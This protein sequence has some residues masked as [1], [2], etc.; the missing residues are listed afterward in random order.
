MQLCAA[1]MVTQGGTNTV[2]I[3]CGGSDHFNIATSGPTSRTITLASESI[4]V[5]YQAST[6]VWTVLTTDTPLAALDARFAPITGIPESAVT[7]LTADL[8][9]KAP[10]AAPTF[11]GHVTVPTPTS[12]TDAVT[13]TYADQLIASADAMVYKGVVDCSANPNY[14]AADAGWTYKISVAGKIGGASGVVVEV[15]DTIMC[16]VDG[17]AS[18]NQATVGTAWG[19][20]QV[21]ID[22]AVVGPTSATD[23]R[24]AIFNGATGK[25]IADGGKLVSDLLAKAGGTMSGAI[26]MGSNKITGATAGTTTGDVATYEQGMAALLTTQG[27]IPYASAANTPARLAKGTAFQI[28]RMNSGATAPEWAS[29]GAQLITE[30]VLG[31]DTASFDFTSI[32]ATYRHLLV[33]WSLRTDAAAAI[34][35]ASTNFNNDTTNAN[36][37]REFLQAAASSTTA[38]EKLA[39]TASRSGATITG[40]TAP[41][42]QFGHGQMLVHNYANVNFFKVASIEGSQWSARTTNGMLHYWNVMGWANTAAINRLTFTPVTGTNFKAQSVVALYG[43]G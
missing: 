39:T 16:A 6:A 43:I 15:G 7:N 17:T 12:G 14:P 3:S 4:L 21:N 42:S 2:T 19:V 20:T 36:Y 28:L 8:A 37:D 34:D 26:A 33:V 38:L 31:V 35:T 1:K 32:P 23:Q 22:G 41:A 10:T 18:G 9:A 13:K 40:N 24:I 30:T 25:V 11:T 29:G 5:M 27:D